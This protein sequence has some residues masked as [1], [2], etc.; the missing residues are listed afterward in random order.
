MDPVIVAGA[1]PV[2]LA[3]ALALARRDVPVILLDE[4]EVIAGAEGLRRSRT[5]VLA[6]A[7]AALVERLGHRSLREDGA[8][9]RG[10]RTVRKRAEVARIDFGAQ[11]APVHL[12]QDRLEDGLRQALLGCGS[13]RIVAGCRVD[14]LEQ[15]GR[16]V[17][18]H[19]GGS[20]DTWWRGSFLVGCDGPRSTVRK[21]LG[22]RFPG[23][24]AVDRHAVAVVR[25]ELP[26][27]G[28]AL[29]HRDPPG[30]PAGQEITA[31]PLREGLWRLDWLLP[32]QA[33]ALT[34]DAL[35]ERLRGT[36]TAWCGSV[37]PYEVVGSAD[38]AV[39]QRLARRW[40]TGRVFLAGD[41]AH[42]MG[43][44]GAQSVE[45]GL[46]DAENL[47]WKLALAWHDGAS[48]VLLDSYEAE[49][50]G[51]V[52]AR[53]RAT[54]QALP[55][56]RASGA[57]QTVRQSLLS[58]SARGQAELLTDSHLGRGTAATS[59]VYARSPLA[60]PAARTGGGRSGASPLLA[61][62]DTPPGGRVDDVQVTA[63]DGTVGRLRERLGRGLVVLLIAPGT[64]VWESR[65]WLTAGLMPRL[66]SAVAALPT[67]AEL[68]VAESYPGATA[69]S[70]LL[71]RP[72]G[73][74]VTT[75]VGCRPAE[76]YSYA[77]L[78]R[79][80]PPMAAGDDTDDV[81]DDAEPPGTRVGG[82]SR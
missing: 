77:D 31:R 40:R 36:L 52:G 54:D 39:H 8:V 15:D 16:G 53:L 42:L 11:D 44:L 7:A 1:G 41:A 37:V 76:L 56:V 30:A 35:V 45:E 81:P 26:E 20:H 18:V 24:T 71:I 17:T 74:L 43:A 72:D 66:A 28:V 27:P 63:L 19:T 59:R 25:A 5:A 23:R 38:Y 57:W 33:R 55:L 34:P 80:G 47:S 22:V 67:P 4:T 68:L 64:G 62:C 48:K 9:W 13:V 49:R 70:V 75:M 3:L 46:R 14:A 58:G 12:A 50:R 6:P 21:L 73:H 29:L 51:A 61:G 82:H 60:V 65:H 78:A 10:W 79:G 69:H 32:A 2:G